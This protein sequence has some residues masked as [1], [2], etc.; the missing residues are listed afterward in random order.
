M[1]LA[2]A[3]LCLVVLVPTPARGE[4]SDRTRYYF[5]VR[6][7]DFFPNVSAARDAGGISLGAN[8][9]RHFGLELALD[10]Y[11][12][13]LDVPDGH[14]E[15]SVLS[16]LPQAR[17][18]YPLLGDKLVPYL[19]A[20]VGLA[21][22]QLND[23]RGSVSLPDG[24]T[25][26]RPMGAVGGGL[27]YYIADNI[28][29]GLEGKYLITGSEPYVSDGVE[30]TVDVDVGLLMLALRFLYPALDPAAAAA[31]A[32]AAGARFYVVLRA[33]GATPTHEEVFPGIDAEPE[34]SVL[35]TGFSYLFG[36][37]LGVDIGRFASVELTI[38]PYELSLSSPDL[39]ALGEYAVFP[40]AAQGRLRYP[41]LE[42]RLV[43]S[44]LGGVGAEVGE[45]NDTTEV[46][47]AL[48]I[49]AKDLTVI[50]T[51]GAGIDYAV[52]SNISLGLQL[53]YVISRGHSFQ[54]GTAPALRGTLDAVILS[55]GLR[56]FLFDV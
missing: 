33:G 21:V 18:R 19:F 13:L 42:G 7:A 56:A 28:A 35:G 1:R 26:V 4:D 46:G 37:A 53:E 44:L 24:R 47:K 23:T 48:H 29:V 41:L 38:D 22:T 32:H 31:A 20:G 51:L 52:M 55:I 14:G 40:I 12:L 16:L 2:G 11:E 8:L 17:A 39:G 6:F 25:Q 5:Q 9:N 50:G 34:Q 45:I 43:P 49:Q 10:S 15:L 54:I 36:A 30:H 27:E 3:L